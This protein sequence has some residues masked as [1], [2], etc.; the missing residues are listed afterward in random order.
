MSA[1][2]SSC[3]SKLIPSGIR[4]SCR[5]QIYAA[6][7]GEGEGAATAVYDPSIDLWTRLA[8]PPSFRTAAKGAAIDGRLFVFGGIGADEE[9]LDRVEVFTP[10]G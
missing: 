7:P 8:D 2:S 4:S 10:D 6:G 1:T 3:T 5:E 9:V